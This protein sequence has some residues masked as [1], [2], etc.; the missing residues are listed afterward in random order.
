MQV[1]VK[2]ITSGADS[3]WWVSSGS[4]HNSSESLRN[5]RPTTGVNSGPASNGN[6]H[7]KPGVNGASGRN[8]QPA[9]GV[10]E[11]NYH[12]VTGVNGRNNQ[13]ATGAS[14]RNN[15]QAVGQNGRS[16]NPAAGVNGYGAPSAASSRGRLIPR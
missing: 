8:V 16:Y 9:T 11:Q 7:A 6:N 13:R 4:F 10:N 14:G 5:Y 2:E 3:P 12:V 1:G 15:Q